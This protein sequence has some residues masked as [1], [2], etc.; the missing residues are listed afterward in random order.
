MK[1]YVALISVL[2]ISAIL[3]ITVAAVSQFGIGEALMIMQ[4]N[5][6]AE[7]DYLTEA[8]AEEALMK[9]A[10]DNNY[11]GNETITINSRSCQILAMENPGGDTRVIKVISAI[12]NQTKRVR[13]EVNQLR[14]QTRV[15]LWQQ[16]ANF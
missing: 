2:I 4:L 14:P 5:K 16:V 1:G 11:A 7:G 15:S 3:L 12:N 13:I 6:S 8:C 9:L 10:E